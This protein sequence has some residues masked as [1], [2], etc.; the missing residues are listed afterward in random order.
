M[1]KIPREVALMRKV[2]DGP[3]SFGRS[4]AV[5]LLDWYYLDQTLILVMERPVSS[6][7]LSKYLQSEGGLS[8]SDPDDLTQLVDA[9]SEILRKGVFHRDIKCANLLVEVGFSVP[10]VRIIDFGCGCSVLRAPFCFCRTLSFAPPEWY[11]IKKYK[12]GPTTVW[13]LGPVLYHLLDGYRFDTTSFVSDR[14]QLSSELFQ[15]NTL[16]DGLDFLKLCLAIHPRKSATLKVL[17]LHPWLK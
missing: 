14:I 10:R 11:I 5:S 3:E 9:A 8:I 2:A 6:M 12:A 1:N 13:Q 4:V 16:P 7:D 15:G 17:K